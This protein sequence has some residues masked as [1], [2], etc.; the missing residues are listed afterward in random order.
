MSEQEKPDYNFHLH[1]GMYFRRFGEKCC[2]VRAVSFDDPG[3]VLVAFDFNGFA[4][5]IAGCSPNCEQFGSHAYILDFLKNGTMFCGGC[6]CALK[7]GE[8]VGTLSIINRPA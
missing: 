3:Q 7:P 1:N 8:S 4:S 2:F 6:G 5:I